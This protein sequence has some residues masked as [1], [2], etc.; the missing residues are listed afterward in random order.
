MV[1]QSQQGQYT[2][3]KKDI[4]RTD[5]GICTGV[6]RRTQMSGSDTGEKTRKTDRRTLYTR[7][8]IKDALLELTADTT[9]DRINVTQL[10]RQAQISRATFYLHYDSLDEV[11][12]AVIDDALLFSETEKGTV[13]DVLD[14]IRMNPQDLR[15]D[16]VLPACQR[17]ADSAKYHHLFMDPSVSAHILQRIYTH[18]KDHVIPDLQKRT[19]LSEEDAQMLFRFILN[20]SFAVNSSL[21][22]EKNARWY[23]CQEILGKFINA[24]LDGRLEEPHRE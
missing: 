12:D 22:W 15:R 14:I 9:Y 6:W 16:A 21:G 2:F 5:P 4:S 11:L 20:G 10:C 19:G 1:Y 8:V 24:G 18:E 7:S 17:I 13:V 23:R 3:L